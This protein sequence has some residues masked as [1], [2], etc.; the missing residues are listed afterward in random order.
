MDNEQQVRSRFAV[1]KPLLAILA[2]SLIV[3]LAAAV[4]LGDGITVLPGT[5]DQ[6]SYHNLALRVAGGHGFSFAENWWPLTRAGAP[7]AHWSFL[8]TL[9][10][11]AVYLVVGVHPLVA[12]VVQV[13]IVGLAMPYLTYRLGTQLFDRRV[14]LLSALV[15]SGYAYFVYYT[16]TLMTE[17]FYITAILASLVLAI[18]FK[19]GLSDPGAPASSRKQWMIAVG[20]GLTLAAAVL[21]RQLFLLFV[22]F[23][24]LWMG[25]G[26]VRRATSKLAVVVLVVVASILP[27]TIYNYIRFDRFVLLN[28]NAGYAM[29]WANHEVYGT[30]FVGILPPELGTYQELI[31]AEYRDLDEAA[32]DSTLMRLALKRIVADPGRY[33]AL[34]V[35]RIPV[36]FKF[37]PSADSGTLSNIARVAS[38]GICWPFMLAGLVASVLASLRGEKGGLRSPAGLIYL[39]LGFYVLLHLLS[40]ALIRYRLPIDAVLIIYAGSS[41]SWLIS[42]FGPRRLQPVTSA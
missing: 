34:S 38:F 14:G 3:R 28:T 36:F 7:T 35:S 31:P 32:L 16:S 2:L 10:L 22:P 21:L 6:I 13:L 4:Y 37:W 27:F 18:K 11:A 33:L 26:H 9:Y 29:Y 25:W 39:F 42:R 23:M 17:P 15:C 1:D 5:H 19:A 40:W 24:V 8:Y 12:R 41:F 30:H 20:L